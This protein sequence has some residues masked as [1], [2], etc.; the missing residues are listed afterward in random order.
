MNKKVLSLVLALVIVL[1]TFGTVFAATDATTESQKIQWLVDNGVLAG[2]TVNADG[3]ADLALDSTITRA[4]TT[5]LV[6]YTLKLQNLADIL[7]G[8]I[9][10]FP[11]VELTHWANGYISVATTQRA[12]VAYGRRIIIGYPDGKFYP[13]NNVTY[14]ELATML[15]RIVKKDLT[16]DMEKNAIWATSYMRWAQE[17]GIL[18]GV[19]VADSNAPAVRRDAFVMI[20]N[21]MAKLGNTNV[22]AP[23]FGDVMGVVSKVQAGRIQLNQDANMEYEITWNSRVTDGT[24]WQDVAANQL[25]PGALV[26]LV[27]NEKGEVLYLI[28]LGSPRQG[29]IDGRWFDVAKKTAETNDFGGRA[30]VA[31][32]AYFF[33]EYFKKIN[34]AGVQAN[35]DSS[36]RFF[37]ADVTKNALKEIKTLDEVFRYYV[38]DYKDLNRVYMGYDDFQGRNEAKVIV[39]GEVDKYQGGTAIRRVTNYYATNY[40]I[41]VETTKGVQEVISYANTSYFP[42]Q[43]YVD[44]MDVIKLYLN[45]GNAQSEYGNTVVG[46]T[47]FTNYPLGTVKHGVENVGGYE[48]LIDY[49]AD[50][51]YEISAV[52]LATRYIELKDEYNY[53]RRFYIKDA[54]VFLEGQAT[55]GKHVQVVLST[56]KTEVEIVSV[57]DKALE[58]ALPTGVRA[59]M[60]DGWIVR[61]EELPDGR[62]TVTI[63]HDRVDGADRNLKTYEVATDWRS[64]V[65]A[66]VGKRVVFDVADKFGATPYIYNIELWTDKDVLPGTGALPRLNPMTNNGYAEKGNLATGEYNKDRITVPA[67]NNYHVLPR[68]SEVTL[69]APA[70]PVGMTFVGFKVTEGNVTLTTNVATRTTTFQ[71]PQTGDVKIEAVYGPVSDAR[72]VNN[73]DCAIQISVVNGVVLEQPR[74]IAPGATVKDYVDNAGK[75]VVLKSEDKVII[76]LV[77]EACGTGECELKAFN[78]AKTCGAGNVISV[79]DI[80]VVTKVAGPCGSGECEEFKCAAEIEL[81]CLTEVE[82]I[83]VEE[84]VKETHTFNVQKT[85]GNDL[86]ITPVGPT[87]QY[88]TFENMEYDV[89]TGTVTG[90]VVLTQAGIDAGVVIRGNQPVEMSWHGHTYMAIVDADEVRVNTANISFRVLGCQEKCT[91]KFQIKVW[92][93]QPCEPCRG[94]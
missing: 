57:V 56:D 9:R 19:T 70:A 66:N 94:L 92:I 58:G 7:K 2:R 86:V 10:A 68:L 33:D 76:Q 40:N 73:G 51:V 81:A 71:M 59:G 55:K 54:D 21:A 84:D 42:R 53:V 48:V 45:Y 43:G 78:V 31:G 88:Y 39:F 4:E 52:N 27:A 18:A 79:D 72:L 74:I 26:R 44:K 3:S 64:F 29:A 14:A 36:T 24:T 63:A 77:G 23:K 65:R 87:S 85:A 28:E 30:A 5:K 80:T 20:Y 16:A 1:G 13:E 38:R 6:V 22:N 83:G 91:G 37:V 75:T 34:V 12:D 46:G 90:T 11:D 15:V 41:T 62:M 17:E 82:A 32:D 60:E 25:A 50:P 89:E 93:D 67:G 47:T 69:H 49:S 35:I 8:V 61:Y